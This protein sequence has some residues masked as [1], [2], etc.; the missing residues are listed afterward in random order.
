[1]IHHRPP[2]LACAIQQ[3]SLDMC[4]FCDSG[5]VKCDA[6]GIWKC[7]SKTCNKV[8]AG[9][10]WTAGPRPRAPLPRCAPPSRVST[11]ARCPGVRGR[12]Q[13]HSQSRTII[14]A[15]RKAWLVKRSS[16]LVSSCASA[17]QVSNVHN[18]MCV[19]QQFS[20]VAQSQHKA[21]SVFGLVSA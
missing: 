13:K 18:M 20:D 4:A 1:M 5:N 17:A 8:M 19:V 3:C 10:C 14:Q 12:L 16:L 11:A 2:V 6:G 9:G 15:E 21:V 7:N